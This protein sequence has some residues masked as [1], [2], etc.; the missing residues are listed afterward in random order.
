MAMT[1]KSPLPS[2][3][4]SNKNNNNNNK[5]EEEEQD[6]PHTRTLRRGDLVRVSET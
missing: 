1:E 5:E 3:S 2:S 6:D 4:S